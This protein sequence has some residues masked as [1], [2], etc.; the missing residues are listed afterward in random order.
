MHICT[1]PAHTLPYP[2]TCMHA[3]THMSKT[4]KHKKEH[5]MLEEPKEVQC[6]WSAKGMEAVVGR[7]QILQE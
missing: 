6:D 5:G 1:P 4:N 3:Y 7:D 2:I